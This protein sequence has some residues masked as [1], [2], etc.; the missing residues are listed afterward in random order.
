ME[1]NMH[2]N[3]FTSDDRFYLACP[4]AEKDDCKALG[5]R[6]DADLKK[7]YVPN[8]TDRELFRRWWKN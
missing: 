1:T 5:G 4:Y 8:D 7:W 3:P 2:N 6:W